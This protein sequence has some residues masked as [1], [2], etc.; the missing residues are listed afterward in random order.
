MEKVTTRTSSGCVT[1]FKVNT[2]DAN[3]P[4]RTAPRILGEYTDATDLSRPVRMYL[5]EPAEPGGEVRHWIAS[6]YDHL[7]NPPRGKVYPKYYSGENPSSKTAA[8][9]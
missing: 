8:L 9:K 3:K 5:C 1:E 2:S 6:K 7:W 4:A